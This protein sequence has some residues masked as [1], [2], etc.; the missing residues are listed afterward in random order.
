M[1][2]SISILVAVF[3][4]LIA[5]RWMLGNQNPVFFF[6]S[7]YKSKMLISFFFT[8]QV[9]HHQTNSNKI[10]EEHLQEESIALHLKW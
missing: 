5:L 3:L 4:I 2:D 8:N 1:N 9:V 6:R 7:I 10:K